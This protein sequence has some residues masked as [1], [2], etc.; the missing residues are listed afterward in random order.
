MPAGIMALSASQAAV[1]SP[2]STPKL[3]Q[4]NPLYTASLHS[5]SCNAQ[6]IDHEEKEPEI[7]NVGRDVYQVDSKW[8]RALYRDLVND[9]EVVHFLNTLTSGYDATSKIWASL[10][11]NGANKTN[12]T[13]CFVT[14]IS[15]IISHFHRSLPPGV[16]R[17][18][19]DTHD[20]KFMHSSGK[21]WTK[22]A[23]SIKA[24]GPSFEVPGS[25]SLCG[26]GFTN[27]SAVF[28]VNT[29]GSRMADN[30]GRSDA[31]C[32]QIFMQQPNRHFVRSLTLTDKHFRL[33]HYDRS[34]TYVSPP[35][36]IHK[37]AEVFVR[38]IIGLSSPN[39]NIL[40]LDTT[41]QWIIDKKTGKKVSG[42]VTLDEY[43][44]E[45]KASTSQIYQLKMDQPPFVR[46]TVRGRGTVGWYATNPRTGEEIIIKDAWRPVHRESECRFLSAARGIPGVVQ[47][48]AYQDHCAETLQYRPR[49]FWAK[50]FQDRVKLRVVMKKY[51]TTLWYFK[52]RL[53]LLRA[54]RDAIVGHRNLLKKGILHR[55]VS[56]HNLLFGPL[57]VSDG[58]HGVLIDLDMAVWAEDQLPFIRADPHVGT[59]MY[60]SISVLRSQIVDPA[61]PQDYLDDLESFFYIFCQLVFSFERPGRLVRSI[62]D[63]LR[64]WNLDDELLAANAKAGFLHDPPRFSLMSSFWGTACK[65]LLKDFQTVIR[66]INVARGEIRESEELDDDGKIMA[67]EKLA[68]DVDGP[69]NKVLS[70]FDRAISALERG[71]LNAEELEPY[72]T[73]FYTPVATSSSSPPSSRDLQT[74][75]EGTLEQIIFLH[76]V[77]PLRVGKK[78]PSEKDEVA[79]PRKRMRQAGDD[80]DISPAIAET[81][82]VPDE[83]NSDPPVE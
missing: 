72:P 65:T 74:P 7:V 28:D 31:H 20:I 63:F 82:S 62:P 6:G 51:G 56:L 39:E 53:E 9:E 29:E 45:T 15:S 27:V 67:Y 21:H 23:I 50:G 69:F 32:R 59:R 77:V 35:L 79:S 43:D 71:G 22:P 13:R 34:G 46:P 41:V 42:T 18:A 48:L 52:S 64:H 16:T 1:T 40:G 80:D 75:D 70:A 11:K 55:D 17:Q 76:D 66:R 78:R 47:F 83:Y 3:L 60:Q 30:I 81:Q 58:L 61:P 25:S 37:D 24:S 12:L 5:R 8:A 49:G 38:V 54:L 14:V 33:V 68:Q 4:P 19:I 10:T 2:G 26:L 36:D 44:E 57:D 73:D